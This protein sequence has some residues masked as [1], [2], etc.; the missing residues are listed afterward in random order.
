MIILKD[1]KL[2]P[3]KI[4]MKQTLYQ[5]DKARGVEYCGEFNM[6]LE[7]SPAVPQ[8]IWFNDEAHFDLNGCVNN[9]NICVWA[10]EHHHNI[11]ETPLHPE[12]CT[13]WCALSTS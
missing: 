11:M 6:F 10:S 2:F 1:V 12:K 4:E 9:Q 8:S 5:A 13:V 3:Y 7:G